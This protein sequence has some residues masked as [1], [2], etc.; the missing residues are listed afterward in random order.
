[1]S[2]YLSFDGNSDTVGHLVVWPVE[3]RL[4]SSMRTKRMRMK[5]KREECWTIEKKLLNRNE[6]LLDSG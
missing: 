5:M 1:L 6:P 3:T 4:K 2:G